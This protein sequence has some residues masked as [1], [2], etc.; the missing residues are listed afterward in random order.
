MKKA[1]INIFSVADSENEKFKLERLIKYSINKA[2]IEVEINV[3]INDSND[4]VGILIKNSKKADI[5]F[6]GLARD[7]TGIEKRT[8]IIERIMYSLNVAVFTQNNGMKNNIPVIFSSTK[9]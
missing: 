7:S 3:L 8:Q 5:V 2:R 9:D 1:V 4:V 6:C